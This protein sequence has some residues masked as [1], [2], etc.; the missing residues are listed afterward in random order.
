MCKHRSLAGGC[1]P[2]N[3][4]CDSSALALRAQ[5]AAFGLRDPCRVPPP[6]RA[7]CA[8]NQSTPRGKEACPTGRSGVLVPLSSEGRVKGREIT[9]CG[10]LVLCLQRVQ[11]SQQHRSMWLTAAG[12]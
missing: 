8:G 7:P 11:S 4:R 10:V 6:P 3:H 12:P 2:Q 9:P 1:R 5:H